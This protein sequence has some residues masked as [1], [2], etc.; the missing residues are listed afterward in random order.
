MVVL[1]TSGAGGVITK[2]AACRAAI[3]ASALAVILLAASSSTLQAQDSG[4]EVDLGSPL[5][6]DRLIHIA[7]E[8]NLS[9]AQS[10]QSVEGVRGSRTGSYANLLPNVSGSWGYSQ[11]ISESSPTTRFFDIGGIPIQIEDP[12]GRTVSDRYNLSIGLNQAL[13]APA[14]WFSFRQAGSSLESASLGLERARDNLAFEVTR[15]YFSLI[16]ARELSRVAHETY[17]LSQE[18][19]RRAQSLFELGSVARSDVLQ[20]QVRVAGSERDRI[21]SDNSVELER[22]RLCLLLA[23]PVDSPLEVQDPPPPPVDPVPGS[24]G[25]QVRLALQNRADFRQ[26]ELDLSGARLGEK[27]A[28]WSRYPSISG[29][30]SYSRHFTGPVTSGED[31]GVFDI[32]RNL[33][34]DAT[35]G[36]SLGL[37]A[38]IFDGLSTKGSIQRA[39]AGRRA[40]EQ[41]LEEKRLSVALEVREASIQIKNASEGIRSAGEGVN[42]AEESVRLQKALYEGGGGTLLEWNNALVELT[43]ARVALVEAE[44]NL[45]LAL[46][47]MEYAVGRTAR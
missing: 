12:G 43:R 36:F 5:S 6:L 41:A 31:V 30:L 18:Q 29:G 32:F 33:D 1:S 26:S 20:A 9:L 34:T 46:A 15:Q 35:W 3:A 16:R 37:R 24:G 40:R 11:A 21:A 19:L 38:S 23:I 27:S 47:G 22:A 28:R 39:T 42:L 8:R 7:S 13:I 2:G 25:E 17:R 44:V 4:S 10:Y 14:A 45:H